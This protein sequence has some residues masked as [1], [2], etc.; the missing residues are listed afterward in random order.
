[1][2]FR[3]AIEKLQEKRDDQLLDSVA[4]IPLPSPVEKEILTVDCM[5]FTESPGAKTVYVDLRPVS[6]AEKKKK[7]KSSALSFNTF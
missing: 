2:A 5:Q 4:R 3:D 6:A 1:M 7:F